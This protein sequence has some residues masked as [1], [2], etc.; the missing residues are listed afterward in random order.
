MAKGETSP[1]KKDESK[2]ECAWCKYMKGGGCR[3]P[4]EVSAAGSVHASLLLAAIAVLCLGH[5]C[6]YV[7]KQPREGA[8]ASIEC[9]WRA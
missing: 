1:S 2:E 3:E 7:T 5:M 8:T 4:F 9:V 6:V